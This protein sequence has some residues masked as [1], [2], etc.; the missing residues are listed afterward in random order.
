[1][2]L[3]FHS[4]GVRY[5]QTYESADRCKQ[6]ARIFTKPN[7]I[8]NNHARLRLQEPSSWWWLKRKY[9]GWMSWESIW[10]LASPRSK[11]APSAQKPFLLPHSSVLKVRKSM[12]LLQILSNN[13]CLSTYSINVR[14]PIWESHYDNQ[15]SFSVPNPN[16]ICHNLQYPCSA[17]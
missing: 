1:M 8:G 6:C 16:L 2:A 11:N 17:H 7:P 4:I 13:N 9:F 12:F 3:S 10:D 14:I 15:L 5:I